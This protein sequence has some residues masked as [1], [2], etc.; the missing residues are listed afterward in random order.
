MKKN[1]RIIERPWGCKRNGG[2]IIQRTDLLE[3]LKKGEVVEFDKVYVGAITLRKLINL[4]PYDDCL[5]RANG[6]L[7]IETVE[8]VIRSR[9]GKKKT[10]FRRPKHYHQFFSI[11]H[12]A[13]MPEHF[14][15]LVVIKPRKF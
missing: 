2:W 3:L 14:K 11:C 7:E 9:N 6:K 1:G 13:W 8:R 12:R 4:L 5:I 10:G 15:R